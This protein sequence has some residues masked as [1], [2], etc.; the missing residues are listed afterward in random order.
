ME[1]LIPLAHE[2]E[3]RTKPLLKAATACARLCDTLG[4]TPLAS[5]LDQ[6]VNGLTTLALRAPQATMTLP[7]LLRVG[8]SD[9]KV[10]LYWL[11]R[12]LATVTC[13]VRRRRVRKKYQ[14]I[15]T[16]Q[17]CLSFYHLYTFPV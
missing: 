16:L 15:I 1:G 12:D 10:H 2:P 13:Y 14:I 17:S 11:H 5:D 7:S 9:A 4:I 6:N 3:L 8:G